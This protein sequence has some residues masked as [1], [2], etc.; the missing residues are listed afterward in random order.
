VREAFGLS[1]AINAVDLAQGNFDAARRQPTDVL[2]LQR[3]LGDRAGQATTRH[4]LA[5]V[6]VQQRNL[7][8]ARHELTDVLALQRELGDRAGDAQPQGTEMKHSATEEHEDE[9]RKLERVHSNREQRKRRRRRSRLRTRTSAR[10][11]QRSG[12]EV[13]TDPI[14]SADGSGSIEPGQE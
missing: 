12:Y 10:E 9:G 8:A 7:D 11:C 13:D 4:T 1:A 3:E 14:R 2:V 6:D 5:A